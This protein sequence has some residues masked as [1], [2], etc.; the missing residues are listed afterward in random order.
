MRGGC[1]GEGG[2]KHGRVVREEVRE[3][4]KEGRER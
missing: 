3:S 4:G 1:M 2:R